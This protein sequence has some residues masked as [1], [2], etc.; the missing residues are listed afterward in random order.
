[1]ILKI[2]I[3]M[4]ILSTAKLMLTPEKTIAFFIKKHLQAKTTTSVSLMMKQ[5]YMQMK[6]IRL[7]N[8]WAHPWL[9]AIGQ[10]LLPRNLTGQDPAKMVDKIAENAAK[11]KYLHNY[12]LQAEGDVLTEWSEKIKRE[13]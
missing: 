8:V 12:L 9:E 2:L 1:M 6:L 3:V 10:F 13:G 11:N 5:H 4:T 7:N